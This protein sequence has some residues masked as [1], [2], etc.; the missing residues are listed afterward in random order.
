MQL[1]QLPLSLGIGA[2]VLLVL[3]AADLHAY[4]VSC[5]QANAVKV[6][7]RLLNKPRSG[8]QLAGDVVDGS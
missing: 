8:A 2:L 5:L 4:W 6:Q 7:K 3:A 1:Q